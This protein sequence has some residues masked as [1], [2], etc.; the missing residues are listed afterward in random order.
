[1]NVMVY[2]PQSPDKQETLYKKAGIIH[3]QAVIHK[4]QILTCSKEQKL[5]LINEL[6]N[7]I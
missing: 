5:K 3:A 7:S 1:M 2:H 4:L 6:I